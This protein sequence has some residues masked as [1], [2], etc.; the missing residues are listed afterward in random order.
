MNCNMAIKLNHDQCLR[1][2]QF[3]NCQVNIVV[4]GG[5]GGW[6]LEPYIYIAFSQQKAVKTPLIASQCLSVCLF[7]HNDCKNSRTDFHEI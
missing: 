5:G 6:G 3:A 4:S 2:S 7:V 1:V